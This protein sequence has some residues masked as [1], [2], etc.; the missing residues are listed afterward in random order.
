MARKTNGANLLPNLINEI[1]VNLT[2]TKN[3]NTT[4]RYWLTRSRDAHHAVNEH[5]SAAVTCIVDDVKCFFEMHPY[6]VLKW[7]VAA[8][9]LVG[10]VAFAHQ[11]HV[12]YEFD[13][14]VDNVRDAQVVNQ[15]GILVDHGAAQKQI[16]RD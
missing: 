16:G 15:I 6:V 14:H 9:V 1:E 3:N 7:I 2:T 12:G 4:Q 5:T 13:G 10:H 8:N 11:V